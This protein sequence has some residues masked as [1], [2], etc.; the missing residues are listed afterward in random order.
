MVLRGFCECG[1]GVVCGGTGK[2]ANVELVHGL[3][4][5]EGQP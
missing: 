4:L 5:M 1:V 3:G 2:A